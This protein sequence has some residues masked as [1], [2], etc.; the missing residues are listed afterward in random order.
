M[1]QKNRLKDP[2]QSPHTPASHL[3][4]CVCVRKR[5]IFK[6]EE[7]SGENDAVSVSNP[8]VRVLA[9]KFKVDGITKYIENND[10]IFDNAFN[11][12]EDTSDLY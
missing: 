4:L 9:P 6:K 12:A 11:E 7:S 8:Q 3:R 1:F 5:P 10:F 2:I